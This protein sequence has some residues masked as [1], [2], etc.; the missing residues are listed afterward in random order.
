MKNVILFPFRNKCYKNVSTLR[1]AIRM[2]SD[3]NGTEL[4]ANYNI[5]F[6]EWNVYCVMSYFDDGMK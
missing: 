3:K 2:E 4:N 5:Q 1:L 6:C